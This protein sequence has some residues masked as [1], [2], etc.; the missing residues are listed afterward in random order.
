MKTDQSLNNM[1]PEATISQIIEANNTAGELLASIGLPLSKHEDETLRSVCQQRKWSEV[2]VLDWIKKYATST[3]GEASQKSDPSLPESSDYT[4]WTSFLHDH[5]I[6]ENQSL[7]NELSQSFPRVLKIH[8]NQYPW[9]KTIK[10]H[11]D[12]FKEALEMYYKF[13]QKKFFPLVE[14]L[15]TNKKKSINHGAVQKI[16]K[17][18]SITERDQDRL[19]RQM[20]TIRD[21]G[22]EFQNP[23]NACS[24]LRIQNQN[25]ELLF[26]KLKEQFEIEQ[27]HLIPLTKEQ[28]LA[29]K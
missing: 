9:L 12:T 28:L 4:E 23:G 29:K 21:K 6:A 17:S 7:L 22:N 25:F 19:E 5:Y 2:E 3:N 14:Q 20:K 15:S 10:W 13:E 26:S 24:T 11:F 16:E 8:G 1:T 27:Q 18:F